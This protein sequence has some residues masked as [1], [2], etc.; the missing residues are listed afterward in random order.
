M[1]RTQ[2]QEKSTDEIHPK[3]AEAASRPEHK[4]WL[5]L[6][7]GV[8]L[9]FLA[10]LPPGIYSID[11]NGMLGVAESLVAHHSFDV[12]PDLGLAGRGGLYYGKWYPLQS[13]LAVPFVA[14]GSAAANKLHLPAH[15]VSAILSLVLPAAFT[16]LTAALV[17]LI[18]RELGSSVRGAYLAAV[19]YVFGTVALVYARA[20]YAEPLL[21]LLTAGAIYFALRGAPQ[22]I[23]WAAVLCGL[24][25]LAKPT[26]IVVGPV[27]ALYLLA[28]K[29]DLRI[30]ILP[31]GGSALGLLS[32]F[33][34]NELRFGNVLTFGQPWKFAVSY[35]PEGLA[36]LLISPGRGL[37]WYCPILLL[38]VAG[39]RAARKRNL[40]GALLVLTVF[41]AYLLLHSLWSFW[42]GGWSWGPRF[43][44]PAIP[45]LAALLG[46]LRG[47]WRHA[48]IVLCCVGLLINA[49]TLFAFY[50]RYYAELT[51]DGVPDQQ[52]EWSMRYAPFLHA[53]PAAIRQVNDA[54]QA[55]VHELFRQRGSSP[56]TTIAT[57]RALRVVAIWWWVLPIAGIP[58]L[59]GAFVSVS[60]MI[61]GVMVLWR[62]YPRASLPSP[63]PL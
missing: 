4:I 30:S 14:A 28:S 1:L 39:V 56:A 6:A 53:W 44:L 5:G 60:M 15:Y 37:I 17:A 25:V 57:S 48:A 63:E 36:G 32:Y 7:G 33:A 18:A 8:A 54:R 59:A 10:L 31:A 16:A 41:V 52:L 42:G 29:R 20:F 24:A 12:P 46:L 51:Q 19:S 3:A 22:Q 61:A 34:Y 43:L 49:P 13:V 62:V 11:G 58:R 47:N 23:T 2:A 27:I 38:A 40:L 9:I 50:E 35:A 55:D 21:A 45:G 26:G